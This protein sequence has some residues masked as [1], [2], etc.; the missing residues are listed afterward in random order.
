MRLSNWKGL[1]WS[2]SLQ[3]P[4]RDL[5]SED[6]VRIYNV[7]RIQTEMTRAHIEKHKDDSNSQKKNQEEKNCHPCIPI[8]YGGPLEIYDLIDEQMLA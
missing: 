7:K 1:V 3:L 8:I 4:D 5:R 2:T 6:W